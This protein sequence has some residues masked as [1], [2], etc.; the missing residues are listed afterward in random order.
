M[1]KTKI[2]RGM[3]SLLIFTF[4]TGYVR[5]QQIDSLLSILETN[6]P[7]EKV[8]LHLDKAYYNPGETIWFK[9]YLATDNRPA[10]ISKTMYADLLDEKG[11]IL[12][13]KMM[14]V[15][16][17]GASSSFDLPDTLPSTRLFVRAYTSWMLNFDTTL[18]YMKPLQIIPAKGTSKKTPPAVVT[19][20]LQLLPEGGDLVNNILSKVA[21]KASDSQGN[22]FVIKGDI[23][24]ENGKKLTAFSSV[25]DGMGLFSI[26]PGAGEK[27]RAVWKDKKGAL[28]ETSLP[29][30]KKQ[31]M[32]LSTHLT[33]NKLNYTLSRPD[34]VDPVFTTYHVVAQMQQRLVYSARI[35]M[36]KKTSVTA[37]IETDSLPNGV[38]QLTVFNAALLPVA[39]RLVFIN[40]GNYSFITDLHSG[41]KNLGKRGRNTLQI[42]IGDTLLSNLSIAVTDAGLNPIT[43]NEESI[44]SQLLLSSDL[45]GYV[46]N[47]AYYFSG[48]EDSVKQ[49]LD[50]VMMTNGWRRFKWDDILAGTWPVIKNLPENYLSING[51]ILGLSKAL[52]YQKQ[53]T[54][55]LKTKNGGTNIFSMTINDKGEF[56][57][58]GLYFID[59]ARLFYQLNNDKDKTLTGSASFSFQ[60]SFV[61]TPPQSIS[62]LAALYAPERNDSAVIQKSSTMASLQRNQVE[63]NRVKTLETVQVR[64]K[65]KS[66][67]EKLDEQY[68]SGFFKGGDGYTFTTEDDPFARSSPSILAYLQG[69]VAGLQISTA[70]Q[71]SAS[72]RGSATSFFLNE[73]N[74]DVST[75]Q[76][77][78]MNDVAMIKIFRPPFF[79]SSGGGSGGAIAIY[80]KKG[81]GDNSQVKGLPFALINGYSVIKEFY[82]PDYEINPEP[83]LKDYRTTLYWNP[84]LYF[85]KDTRRITIPFFNSDNCKKIRVTI[86]GVNEAG[87]NQGRR[88]LNNGKVFISVLQLKILLILFY[89]PEQHLPKKVDFL[90]QEISVSNSI[91][92]LVDQALNEKD[93]AIHNFLQWYV[94]EQIEEEKSAGF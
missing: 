8:H 44:Y 45:K 50:L 69:K 73:V 88:S 52:L 13:R 47:P 9:A 17:S 76:S 74:A 36:T 10:S 67:K 42:D 32:V 84:N 61:K 77:I 75:L 71:G 86:E 4:F 1:T 51:R 7:Q 30:V 53:L 25:H 93:Y 54:G 90:N 79:G 34:S 29:D 38:L 33:D 23:V 5:A 59:T 24:D 3:A 85:D 58:D 66:L 14:V 6:Y 48:D 37:P 27:Y 62:M 40:H 39:E 91:S 18:L 63:N 16:E 26:Q 41:E 92:D 15:L 83:D 82:S 81:G 94:S 35:N 31:G 19:Y 87:L 80:T 68:T 55:I 57:Q 60:N 49:H 56:L 72:W 22:P 43:K 12:Q 46:Y 20:N 89:K 64:T 78:S 65:Q 70:G 21:F 11:T 28:H 2:Y